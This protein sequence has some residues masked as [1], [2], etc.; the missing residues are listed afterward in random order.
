M[1]VPKMHAIIPIVDCRESLSN[2]IDKREFFCRKI[3]QTILHPDQTPEV[4]I[5][6]GCGWVRSKRE[7]YKADNMDH[8]ETV[9]VSIRCFECNS[10]NNSM[11]LDP[12]IYDKETINNFLPIAECGRGI[13][14]ANNEFFCRKIIQTILH[15]GYEPE[16]RVTRSCGWVRHHRDCYK[17]DNE[18]HLET[19]CQCFDNECNSAY[20]RKSAL[21]LVVGATVMMYL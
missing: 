7:C 9:S 18:D 11:C 16:V 2:T 6:R 15:K 3:T 20:V 13:Y 4:R 10:M 21:A 12:T 19:V 17:A 8:L 1:H 14:S 5:T